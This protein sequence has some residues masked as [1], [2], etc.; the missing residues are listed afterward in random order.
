MT[1][2]IIGDGPLRSTLESQ[3]HKLGIGLAVDFVGYV[4]KEKDLYKYL[5]SADAFLLTSVTEGFPRV[6]YE[7]MA[8]RLPIV[9]TNVGGIPYLLKNETDA[10]LCEVG[11]VNDLSSALYRVITDPKLRKHLIKNASE[12]LEKVFDRSEPNQIASLIEKKFR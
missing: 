12:T 6:L 8:H 11:D 5:K 10:V 3:A 1:L 7:A 2:T 4:E 9:T